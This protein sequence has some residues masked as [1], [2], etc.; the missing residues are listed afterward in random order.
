[1]FRICRVRKTALSEGNLQRSHRK[2]V[3]GYLNVRKA[4]LR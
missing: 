1:M 4:M 2:Q 3:R